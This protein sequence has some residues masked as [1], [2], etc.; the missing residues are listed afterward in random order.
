MKQAQRHT[1]HNLRT[2]WGNGQ[3]TMISPFTNFLFASLIVLLIL[4][5]AGLS[6]TYCAR[7]QIKH[8]ERGRQVLGKHYS[9]EATG[10]NLL[11]TGNYGFNI[12][13]FL[14]FEF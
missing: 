13:Y 14:N 3:D 11:R 12:Y 10:R 9:S 8:S 4:C 1:L 5:G 2:D 6:F 7:R